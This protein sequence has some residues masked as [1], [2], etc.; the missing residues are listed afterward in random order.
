MT[1]FRKE[2]AEKFEEIA[3][4]L[5]RAAYHARVT[6]SHYEA[7]NI[8]RAGAHTTALIGHLTNVKALLEERVK[9]AARFASNPIDDPEPPSG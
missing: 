6:A 9:I 4:E 3:I 8:P 1:D 7:Q 2:A 5:E